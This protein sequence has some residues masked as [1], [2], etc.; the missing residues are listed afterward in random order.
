[1]VL[2][3]GADFSVILFHSTILHMKF[4][5]SIFSKYL[6][7][8]SKFQWLFGN[9]KRTCHRYWCGALPSA[10]IFLSVWQQILKNKRGRR[11]K[12][13]KKHTQKNIMSEVKNS[14]R[15]TSRSWKTRSIQSYLLP[16]LLLSFKKTK[17]RKTPG[18]SKQK[19][20]YTWRATLRKGRWATYSNRRRVSFRTKSRWQDKNYNHILESTS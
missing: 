6:L 16:F 2:N 17:K 12:Q 8:R 9:E 1:M 18:K 7:L 14:S 11:N 15:K 10:F 4:R 13:R 5:H 19:T 3:V 20:E